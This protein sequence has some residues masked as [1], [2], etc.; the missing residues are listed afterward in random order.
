MSFLSSFFLVE[1]HKV[2]C[3]FEL[4]L[5]NEDETEDDDMDDFLSEP[6]EDVCF[7]LFLLKLLFPGFP[8]ILFLVQSLLNEFLYQQSKIRTISWF[9]FLHEIVEIVYVHPIYRSLLSESPW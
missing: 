2:P 4:L 3:D 7:M 1:L 6:D 5:E 8:S 9:I